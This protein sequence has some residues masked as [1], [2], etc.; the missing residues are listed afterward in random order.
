MLNQPSGEQREVNLRRQNGG[1]EMADPATSVNLLTGDLT[2]ILNLIS[3]AAA[4]GTAAMGL[5]DS[6]KAFWGGPSNFGF[7]Y[8]AEALDPFLIR[9]PGTPTAFGKPEVL[10]T[11]KA[12]WLNGVA[13]ADQKAKAKA[14]IHLG[15]ATGNAAALANAAGVDP[16]KLTSLTRNISTGAT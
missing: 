13:A 3:A 10:R 16:E 4:L 12:N 5:V 2:G 1:V 9:A 15:L 7:G 14:L 8:V 11:L 6:A